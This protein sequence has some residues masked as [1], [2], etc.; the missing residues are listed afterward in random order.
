MESRGGKLT[1]L[2]SD[3]TS[4]KPKDKTK[5]P[6]NIVTY[7]AWNLF[8][9]CA[10]A[11]YHR[12]IKEIVPKETSEQIRLGKSIHK[13][14]EIWHT[15]LSDLT[16]PERAQKLFCY[17]DN[18]FPHR[19]QYLEDGTPN[20][21]YSQS[22]KVTW[23]KS[24]AMMDGYINRYPAEDFEVIAC[25]EK[26][27]LE[28]S[29]PKTSAV[30]KS[31]RLRGKRDLDVV[32]ND[33]KIFIME[34]K[35]AASIDDEYLMKLPMDTQILLYEYAAEM[36]YGKPIDGIIYNV[37]ETTKIQPRK[38]ETEEEFQIRYA[39]A[40]AKN[41]SGKSNVSRNFPET[42]EQFQARLAE[43]Y[44]NPDSTAY[45]REV[46]LVSND[47]RR[48]LRENLWHF[49]QTLLFTKRGGFW[50]QNNSY[51]FNF[52]RPCD[53]YNLCRNMD[54]PE[55]LKEFYTSV[56]AHVELEDDENN[57]ESN[58]PQEIEETQETKQQQAL[59]ILNNATGKPIKDVANELLKIS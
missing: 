50:P 9:N 22:D 5:D 41:K 21:F 13:C 4:E 20:P 35:T 59:Q 25:E 19:L 17:I 42:D 30:S 34:H 26:F 31:F 55:I 1:V 11:Y 38:G 37:I 8:R 57:S 27:N 3:L 15:N 46:I 56:K 54:N 16:P 28:I 51:C 32:N 7:S 47:L 52:H 2:T 48:V 18:Q 36:C 10:R 6:K 49:T 24:R 14:L 53:Y 58:K 12:Y 44:N 33:Q 45:H 29:N 23:M 39:E 43:K 40:C